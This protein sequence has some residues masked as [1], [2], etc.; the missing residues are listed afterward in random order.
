[1]RELQSLA[2]LRAADRDKLVRALDRLPPEQRAVLR[3]RFIEERGLADTAG[4]LGT[5]ESEVKRLQAR[6]LVALRR[7]LEDEPPR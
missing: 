1:L 6:A 5:T 3:L 7:E 2:R 4:A